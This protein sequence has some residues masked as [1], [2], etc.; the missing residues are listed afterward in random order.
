MPVYFPL[1]YTHLPLNPNSMFTPLPK[2]TYTYFK[3]LPISISSILDKAT[4]MFSKLI[5]PST[6]F[7]PPKH[8]PRNPS[9][10]NSRRTSRRK[11]TPFAANRFDPIRL[12]KDSS[13]R[14]FTETVIV[15][16]HRVVGATLW[17]A[18]VPPHHRPHRRRGGC[19]RDGW[20]GSRGQN[21]P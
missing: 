14:R 19:V 12:Q 10:N 3:S 4:P 16:K 5:H 15:R 18:S 13:R 6:S 9:R 2:T 17:E 20:R 21:S 8:H 1:T 7:H 11:L